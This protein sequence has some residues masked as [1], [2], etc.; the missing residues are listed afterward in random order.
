[1][2]SQL[3]RPRGMA[4]VTDDPLSKKVEMSNWEKV[5]IY[6]ANTSNARSMLK[7]G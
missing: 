3:A 6:C 7:L 4:T 5:P 2:V 1:M